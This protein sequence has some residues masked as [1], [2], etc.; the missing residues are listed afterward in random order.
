MNMIAI[1]DLP[2]NTVPGRRISNLVLERSGSKDL[3]HD[4][5]VVSRVL[6]FKISGHSIDNL[7]DWSDVPN[8][9]MYRL[10]F[11]HRDMLIPKDFL[12]V[13]RALNN[14]EKLKEVVANIRTRLN[15]HPGGQL[16]LNIPVEQSG[17]QHK[18]SETVLVFP[19]QG[20]TCHSYCSYCFRWAQFIGD[21]ELKLAVDTPEVMVAY[22]KKHRHVTDV[23]LTGGD[24]LVMKTEKLSLYIKALLN[25]ELDHIRTIRIGTKALSFHP[26]RVATGP[27]ADALLELSEKV[28]QSGKHLTYMLHFSHPRE[29]EPA[30]TQR[31][32][33]R[34]IGTGSQLRSQSPVINHVNNDSSA[35]ADMWKQQVNCGIHPYYMFVERD[36]GAH[37]YFGLPLSQTHEIY[38]EAIRQV[39]GLAR[40]A[41]G[42]VMSATPGK[43]VI[44]GTV[45]LPEGKAFVLRFL[46]ARNPELVGRPFFAKWSATAQWWDELSPLGSDDELFFKPGASYEQ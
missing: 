28:I 41:R 10:L 4:V 23:L 27:D 34:L 46:Q 12:E 9:P 16:N 15:P 45:K 14:S 40:T 32:I 7:I 43:V 3:A 8:D 6:P 35:W 29:I 18:Y 5:D 38:T 30:I 26:A 42:P 11:P 33:S 20:Q 19:K 2:V 36:T 44:D 37:H 22:L 39:S 13:E 1:K 21:D 24:P 17:L 25:P 31:A